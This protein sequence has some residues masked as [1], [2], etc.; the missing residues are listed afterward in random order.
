M[1]EKNKYGQMHLFIDNYGERR[2]RKRDYN[3][4]PKICLILFILLCILLLIT[5]GLKISK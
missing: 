4:L 5:M 3:I 2:T 1:R